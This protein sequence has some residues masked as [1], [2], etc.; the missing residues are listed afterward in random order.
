MLSAIDFTSTP[1]DYLD[2]SIEF[3]RAKYSRILFKE[4]L[5]I[6]SDKFIGVTDDYITRKQGQLKKDTRFL[7]SGRLVQLVQNQ[8]KMKALRISNHSD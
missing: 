4:F 2:E 3:S 1:P 8:L 7:L 6:F 5:N